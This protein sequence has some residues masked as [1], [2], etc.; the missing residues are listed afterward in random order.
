ML[1][2]A[3]ELAV[4]ILLVRRA[5]GE[6]FGLQAAKLVAAAAVARLET[7]VEAVQPLLAKAARGVLVVVLFPFHRL[8]IM[9]A[10]AAEVLRPNRDSRPP[11]VQAVAAAG[12]RVAE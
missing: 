10:A 12:T 2:R 3:M 6:E 11:A 7:V 9:A 8:Q 5:A 4:P 1:V